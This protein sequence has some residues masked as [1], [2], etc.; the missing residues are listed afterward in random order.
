M[1]HLE[2]QL[3]NAKQALNSKHKKPK[4]VDL[5]IPKKVIIRYE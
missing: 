2:K 4:Y 3:K 1:T 5:R